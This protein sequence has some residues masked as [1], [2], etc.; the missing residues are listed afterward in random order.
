MLLQPRNQVMQQL[1]YLLQQLF[2]HQ[3]AVVSLLQLLQLPYQSLPIMLL[4]L[5][6]MF[7]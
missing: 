1:C 3:A 2:K 4:Q 7:G 6:L 5:T